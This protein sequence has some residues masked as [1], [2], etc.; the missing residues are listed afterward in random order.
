ML[1]TAAVGMGMDNVL[2]GF[3]SGTPVLNTEAW[4]EA[5]ALKGKTARGINFPSPIAWMWVGF[6][7]DISDV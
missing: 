1:V 6:A 7:F 3:A 5:R 2:A 4:V